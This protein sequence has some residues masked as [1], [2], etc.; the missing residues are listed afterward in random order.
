[1][2]HLHPMKKKFAIVNMYL[3]MA[4]LFTILF[5]SLHTYRH[6]VADYL[7]EP[8]ECTH[9]HEGL[10]HSHDADDCSVCDF[11]FW[12]YIKPPIFNYRFDIPLKPVPYILQEVAHVSSFSGSLFSHRGPPTV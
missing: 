8:Q 3:M 12:Y 5:Q 6:L 1:M 7:E 2:L 10:S 11:T 4:V 9:S